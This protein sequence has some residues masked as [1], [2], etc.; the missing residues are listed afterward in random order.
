[1]FRK[2]E[3]I[4]NN[5]SLDDSTIILKIPYISKGN[6]NGVAVLTK[7]NLKEVIEKNI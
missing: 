3:K 7:K 6:V 1:M 4:M 5:D 2:I